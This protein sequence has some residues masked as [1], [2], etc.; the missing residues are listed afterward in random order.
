MWANSHLSRHHSNTSKESDHGERFTHVLKSPI[1]AIRRHVLH[2]E[3]DVESDGEQEVRGHDRLN[4]HRHGRLHKLAHPNQH[5][6]GRIPVNGAAIR[7]KDQENDLAVV[8]RRS[9][10]APAALSLHEQTD[11]AGD[12][13]APEKKPGWSHIEGVIDQDHVTT[14]AEAQRV[15]PEREEDYTK[16][17]A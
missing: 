6:D 14:R 8:S 10:V 11:V 13:D 17:E 3:S 12:Q 2:R 1:D 15:D 9:S 16:H 7:P 4:Q 5:R